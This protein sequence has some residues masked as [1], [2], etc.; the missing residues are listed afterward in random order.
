MTHNT[1]LATMKP[2]DRPQ[3]KTQLTPT[4]YF[5]GINRVHINRF[6]AYTQILANSLNDQ[7]CITDD[8]K[9]ANVVIELDSNSGEKRPMRLS[10]LAATANLK[11]SALWSTLLSF[12]EH[13]LV[14]QLNQASRQLRQG[15][16][17]S[18]DNLVADKVFAVCNL[19]TETTAWSERF[20]AHSASI[21][22]E[23]INDLQAWQ[24]DLFHQ[25]VLMLVD[26]NDPDSINQCLSLMAA[27]SQG[28]LII[29]QLIVAITDTGAAGE[30]LFDQIYALADEN[31]QVSTLN[32]IDAS[33]WQD[34]VQLL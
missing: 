28:D 23:P 22:F 26:P 21:Q 5:R 33:Q 29:E 30:S 13:E 34:F 1:T 2:T 12:T 27:K 24:D 10:V 19:T 8:L 15:F 4:V 9:Q 16:S 14:R 32:P 25:Q 11:P 18:P 20:Q 6:K 3:A 31:T 17:G 7:W